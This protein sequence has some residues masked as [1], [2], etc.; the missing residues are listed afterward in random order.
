VKGFRQEEDL[1]G[2][3]FSGCMRGK[4]DSILEG[5][6][7]VGLDHFMK[8]ERWVGNESKPQGTGLMREGRIP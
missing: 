4:R 3:T 6:V 2:G 1:T 7:E 8:C 5:G